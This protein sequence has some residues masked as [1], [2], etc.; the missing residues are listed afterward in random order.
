MD[1]NGWMRNT[2]PE[3]L[4]E[5]QWAVPAALP[6][7]P[8]SHIAPGGTQTHHTVTRALP[9]QASA[10]FLE[11]PQTWQFCAPSS[12]RTNQWM[13]KVNSSRSKSLCVPEM[14]SSS[15]IKQFRPQQLACQGSAVAKCFWH[16]CSP[17][18]P[19][20]PQVV[21]QDSDTSHHFFSTISP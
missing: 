3:G 18:R 13:L 20:Q 10:Y 21:V 19:S 6:L 4:W 12:L 14:T 1:R 9:S 16:S 7:A 11:N 2:Q 15:E 8:S 5:L 17:R